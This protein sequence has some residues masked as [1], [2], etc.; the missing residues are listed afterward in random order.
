MARL[1]VQIGDLKLKNPVMTASGTFGYGTEY[2]DFIDLGRLGGI[3]VKGTTLEPREGNDYPRMAETS[4]GMLNSVGLQ[5]KGVDYFVEHL[6]PVIKEYNTHMIVNVSGS[7]I[8]DYVACA[9]KLADLEKMPAIELNI[10]CPNV[11]EGGMAFGTSCVSAAHVTRE[12][13]KVF[14]KTLIVKLSPNVTDI[15]GIARSVEDEGADAVSLVNTFLGM[16][17]DIESR[18]PKLSTVTGGLSGPCIK[19]I[20]LR[21]VWEVFNAVKIPI[22]GIGGISNWQDAIEFILAGAVAVQIG[23]YNFIDPAVSVKVVEGINNYLDRHNISSIKELVGKM[24]VN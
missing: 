11:K 13:R 22:I 5:N 18:K 23:T 6:Y 7:S 1:E 12:V 24:I 20:A 9:E 16:A 8:E 19:P 21:M 14:P 4:S 17:I 15:S 3:F 2:A 10:S